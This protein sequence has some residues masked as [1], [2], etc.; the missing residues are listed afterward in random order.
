M[1]V[2]DDGDRAS[3]GNGGNLFLDKM[4]GQLT[5]MVKVKQY[6]Y[7]PGVGQRVPGS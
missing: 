6:R 2:T 7:R 1:S 5:V 3:F 4:P